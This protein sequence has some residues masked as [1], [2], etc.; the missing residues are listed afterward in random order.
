MSI[1]QKSCAFLN[2]VKPKVPSKILKLFEFGFKSLSIQKI[3]SLNSNART[4]IANLKTAES[5]AYRLAKNNRLLNTVPKFLN[6]LGIVKENDLINLDFSDFN[7]RQVLMFAK[8]TKEGR[9]IPLYF[10]YLTYPIKKGSQNIFIMQSIIRFLELVDKKVKFVFDRGFA[11]PYIVRFLANLSLIFY[12]RIKKDKLVEINKKKIKACDLERKDYQVYVYDNHLR[13]IISD[14]SD[15]R[16]EPWYIITND[17]D[18][19][20]E[21]IL[22]IYYHRFEIEELFRDAKRIFG[23]EHIRLKK[24][25]SFR[26]VLWFVILGTWFIWYMHQF[27]YY[28]Q[29]RTKKFKNGYHLSIIYYWLERI[30]YE[31]KAQIL[32]QIKFDTS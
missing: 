25:S 26:I 4:T 16:K 3:I 14:K 2:L 18:N 8:Q 32:E 11:S 23:L 30:Q 9:A 13:L 5:K 22:K 1:I 28:S 15:K 21:E 17:Q 6:H 24:D 27:I 29:R 10:E 19:L 31:I 20:R 12:V 7:G